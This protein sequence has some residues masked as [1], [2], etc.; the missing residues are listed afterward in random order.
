MFKTVLQSALSN[1]DNYF[2]YEE[3]SKAYFKEYLKTFNAEQELAGEESEQDQGTATRTKEICI[4]F[5]E[6]EYILINIK[7]YYRTETEESD[8]EYPGSYE[9]HFEGFD[10][11]NIENGSSLTDEEINLP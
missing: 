10:V 2:T 6:E 1:L 4:N 8:H 3:L 5:G 9:E 11:V 7:G